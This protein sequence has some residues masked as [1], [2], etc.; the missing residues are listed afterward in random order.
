MSSTRP[1][2]SVSNLPLPSASTV[3]CGWNRMCFSGGSTSRK[4]CMIA[5]GVRWKMSRS[6]VMN[7]QYDTKRSNGLRTK[8]NLKYASKIS[9]PT[10]GRT[11]ASERWPCR[12]AASSSYGKRLLTNRPTCSMSASLMCSRKA[13]RTEWVPVL[14]TAAKMK[15]CWCEMI[16]AWRVVAH[17][18]LMR[19]CRS[20]R[21]F[22]PLPPPKLRTCPHTSCRPI[23]A[24]NSP[25]P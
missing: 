1:T 23:P 14:G 7:A 12:I 9:S 15:R 22:A 10:C 4:C 17:G 3:C 19:A 6:R 20:H 18:I 2:M 8:A 16:M 11:C 25:A 24:K 13:C 5:C 21:A